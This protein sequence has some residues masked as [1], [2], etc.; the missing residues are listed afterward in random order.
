MNYWCLPEI[1]MIKKNCYLIEKEVHLDTPSQKQQS[2]M[3]PPHDNCPQ[4][5]ISKVSTDFFQSYCWSKNPAIW[6]DM[7]HTW[8]NPTKNNSLGYYLLLVNISKQIIN[9]W[10]PKI[11]MSKQSL[12][13]IEQEAH[14]VTPS[15]K[16]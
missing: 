5:K 12:D 6:L 2:Q 14:L 11:L 16:L 7:K 13:W 8:Q 3:P 10:L 1:L 9:R 15:N 4:A